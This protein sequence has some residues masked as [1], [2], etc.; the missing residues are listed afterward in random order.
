MED[1]PVW[2][3]A[4]RKRIVD[5]AREILATQPYEQVQ[6]R[7]VASAAGVAL[8]TL[9]RYFTSKEHLYA[10]VLLDWAE[11]TISHRANPDAAPEHR[12]DTKVRIVIKAFRARPEFFPLYR[13]LV[14]SDQPIV[15]ELLQRYSEDGHRFLAE[16]LEVLGDEAAEDI[17]HML[18]AVISHTVAAGAAGDRVVGRL[19]DIVVP[20]IKAARLEIEAERLSGA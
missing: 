14:S 12:L 8:G 19:L 2:Q 6:V 17:A 3:V 11:P 10:V 18:W 20:M 13:T 15:A 5:A 9:Y 16:E 1:L 7:D 4:R